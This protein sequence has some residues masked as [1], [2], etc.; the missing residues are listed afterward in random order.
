MQ[1]VTKKYYWIMFVLLTSGISCNKEG[2][3]DCVKTTGDNIQEVRIVGDF[4]EIELNQGVNL[5]LT[6]SSS[7][8]LMIEGGKNLL[9]KV[10]TTVESGVLVMKNDNGCNWTRSLKKDINVYVNVFELSRITHSGHGTLSSTNTIVANTLDI[11]IYGNGDLQ[12]DINIGYLYTLVQNSGD[13]ILNGTAGGHELYNSGN[14]WIRC[15][16]LSTSYTSVNCN[17]TGDCYIAASDSLL[18][19]INSIGSV[20][21]SGNPQK[22]TSIIQGEGALIKN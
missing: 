14:N 5:I 20:F 6:Q 11:S 13:L 9:G 21:Y 7:K 17:S 22:V 8:S 3:W 19:E 18:V 4:T 2:A 15:A 1:A 10:T 12:L 16:G